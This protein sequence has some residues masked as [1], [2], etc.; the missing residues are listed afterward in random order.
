MLSE[1]AQYHIKKRYGITPE[2][3]ETLRVEHGGNC[4]VCGKLENVG[5]DFCVKDGRTGSGEC[6]GFLCTG[7]RAALSN[8]RYSPFLINKAKEYIERGEEL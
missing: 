1:K 4:G 3:Y 8:L 2:E 5:I 7:C 6:R